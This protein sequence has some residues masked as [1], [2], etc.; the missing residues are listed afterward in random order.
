MEG[1]DRR[2]GGRDGIRDGVIW[3]YWVAVG[4]SRGPLCWSNDRLRL[5]GDGHACDAGYASYWLVQAGMTLC[6]E[7]TD[8]G[9]GRCWRTSFL[10]ATPPG[11]GPRATNVSD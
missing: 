3:G 10:V 1:F 9:G 7:G 11:S 4:G 2:C 6:C 5:I 8:L